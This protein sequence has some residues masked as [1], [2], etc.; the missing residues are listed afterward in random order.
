MY[1]DKI[2]DVWLDIFFYYTAKTKDRTTLFLERRIAST[3]IGT[4][5]FP[6]ASLHA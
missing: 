1:M 4:K 2:I 3:V 5:T 6:C